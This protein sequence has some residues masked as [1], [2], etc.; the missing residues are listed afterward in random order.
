MFS[1]QLFTS[2]TQKWRCSESQ[3]EHQWLE[4]PVWAAVDHIIEVYGPD[5]SLISP[6]SYYV[7]SWMAPVSYYWWKFSKT[8]TFGMP[9]F[10]IPEISVADLV[11]HC[12]L[13]A[14]LN[15]V[16]RASF[17]KYLNAR[18]KW[19]STIWFRCDM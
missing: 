3:P 18:E 17:N 10:Y 8:K 5:Y 11:C 19:D 7:I 15:V 13:S 12:I 6:P 14:K 2:R 1:Y 4:Q 9:Y 16:D